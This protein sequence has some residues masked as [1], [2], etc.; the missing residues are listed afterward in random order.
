[1]VQVVYLDANLVSSIETRSNTPCIPSVLV[2]FQLCKDAYKRKHLTAGLLI[3]SEGVSITIMMWKKAAARQARHWCSSSH[4]PEG[5]MGTG[6][7][8]SF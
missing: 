8:M 6:A 3:A 2:T 5:A 7:S 4:K 1:M